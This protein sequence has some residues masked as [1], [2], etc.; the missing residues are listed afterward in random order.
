MC[1][2]FLFHRFMLCTVA[3]WQLPLL[4]KKINISIAFP[5]LISLRTANIYLVMTEPLAFA[6]N[7]DH[8]EA[9]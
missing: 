7:H 5:I 3:G 2:F 6:E 1:L 8:T 4:T 9:N